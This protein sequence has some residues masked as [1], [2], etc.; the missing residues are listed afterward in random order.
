MVLRRSKRIVVVDASCDTKFRFDDLGNTMRKIRI[1]LGV[2]ID[3]D[4]NPIPIGPRSGRPQPGDPPRSYYA[5]ATIKYS[6]VDPL[7]AGTTLAAGAANPLDGRLLYIKPA[8]YKTEPRDVVTY[9]ALHKDF[10]HDS[11]TQ[12]W[13]TESQFESYRALGAHVADDI[14]PR[15][16]W[17][18]LR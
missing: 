10:P 9:A 2:P 1:D 14:M 7:P 5:T 8:V 12:Q 3:F 13:Y 4:L 17:D 11:T 6:C 18:T 16:T 15:L